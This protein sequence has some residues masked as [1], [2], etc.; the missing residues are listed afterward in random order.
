MLNKNF[1][2]YEKLS[3][4]NHSYNK[5]FLKNL[6]KILKTGRYINGEFGEK[7][8]KEFS[9]FIGVKYSIGVSNGLDGLVI[10]LNALKKVRKKKIQNEVIVPANTYIASI[11]SIIHSGLKPILVEPNIKDYNID[12]EI[13][14][15]KIT[16]NTLA[17]MPVHLYGR[18]VDYK[19]L[20]YFKKKKIFVIEDASQAHGA[21]INGKMVGSFGDLAVFSC[22]PGKNL[23][24]IGD[25][26]IITTNSKKL[27]D[28]TR[29]LKNYGSK[30][31]YY[32]E[33]LG[34]INR[35]DE[36]HSAFLIEK[37]KGLQ[38]INKKKI[39]I[40][41][42]YDK[43]LDDKV[44]K[45]PIDKNYNVFHIYPIR[46]KNRKKFIRFLEKQK[47]PF[48]IH[49]PVAPHKQKALK[50]LMKNKKFPITEKIHRTIISLPIASYFSQKKIKEFCLKI[51]K[52]YGK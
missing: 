35:M 45:P 38:N 20:R 28:I 6:K 16:K 18:P 3:V 5:V 33:Y 25:A 12:L 41:N 48:N 47:V 8:E 19:K 24:S 40:A 43:L 39:K 34:F 29:I 14:K 51:N 22:Y 9:K 7:L 23:G 32:N 30:K 31:K 4:T 37:L 46:V 27:A 15:K 50:K 17:I 52:F 1:K 11:I 26:G 42:I 44:I 36:V 49:Y 13:A 21:H 2:S 10:S